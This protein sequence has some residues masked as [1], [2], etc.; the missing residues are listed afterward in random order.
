MSISKIILNVA[1]HIVNALTFFVKPQKN[2]ITFISLTS[3][4]LKGDFEQIDTMLKKE[5]KYD[6]HYNLIVFK[7]TL[8]SEIGYFFNCLKQLVECKKSA[9][10]IINDNNYVI[11]NFK[12]DHLKVL[13]VWHACGAIKKFGN[14]IQRQYPIKGYDKI[15][16]SAPAWKSIYAKSFGAKEED[17]EVTGLPRIDLLLNKD[18]MEEKAADFYARHPECKNKR[19]ILYA[20]T[21]RGNI[22]D[23]LELE[24]FD[25]TQAKDLLKKEDI[26]LYRFH[27]LLKFD[28]KDYEE[29]MDVSKEDLN[30]LMYISDV[31]VSDYSSVLLDYSLLKKPMAAYV[32]D[33]K[34]YENTIGLN[35]DFENEFPGPL[36]SSTEE[37]C[38]VLNENLNPYLDLVEDF[39]K[40]YIIYNDGHNTERIVKLID[41]MMSDSKRD[42]QSGS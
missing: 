38:S 19:L 36:T 1:L 7:H 37:L 17:I 27:P 20:P 35:I 16:C 8:L 32:P 12:M 14:E 24:S 31:L 33:L 41:D 39:Q 21:F 2:R 9:L 25:F 4:T 6:I 34:E 28:P 42:G 22:I 40:K 30:M 29:G 18:L 15:L 5:G 13:Q 3:D 26:I 10:V 11:S 23:G